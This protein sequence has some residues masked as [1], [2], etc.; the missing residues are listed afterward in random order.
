MIQVCPIQFHQVGS[1][2]DDIL[3]GL[4]FDY[5]YTGEFEKRE[6]VAIYRGMAHGKQ[7]A[8]IKSGRPYPDRSESTG[9][10]RRSRYAALSAG[11]AAR[12]ADG[13]V[14]KRRDEICLDHDRSARP[15]LPGALSA[16]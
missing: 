11:S 6:Q 8:L 1:P 7:I 10:G 3:C 12:G 4:I 16:S 2:V 14:F 13:L 9:R 5:R 15:C